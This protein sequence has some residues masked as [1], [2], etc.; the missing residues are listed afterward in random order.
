[1]LNRGIAAR[2]G[3]TERETAACSCGMDVVWSELIVGLAMMLC[4]QN[5]CNTMVLA[6]AGCRTRTD[7]LLF[8]REML[9]Q[10]S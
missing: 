5:P 8:T 6:G 9:Y 2:H 1:M 3:C 10:L 7:D 4:P